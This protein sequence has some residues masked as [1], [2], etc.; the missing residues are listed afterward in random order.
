TPVGKIIAHCPAC[1]PAGAEVTICVRPENLTIK[2][3]ADSPTPADES[4]AI[5]AKVISSMYL[6]EIRQ[7]T[8]GLSDGTT[9]RV[10]LLADSSAPLPA[11][12]AITL[13]CRPEN[14]VVLT[15]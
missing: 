2:P 11:G 3:A 4:S 7:Y 1:P 6:G 14:V 10:S 15:K 12:Q 5:A 9:W 8:C 13:Y